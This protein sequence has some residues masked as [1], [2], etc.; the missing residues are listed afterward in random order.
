MGDSPKV[1]IV[2]LN[3]NGLDFLKDCIASIRKQTYKHIEIVVTDNNSSDGS[4]EF[5]RST[6]D[7]VLVSHDDNYG[8]AR[9]NND[10]AQ[11]A[12]GDFLFFLNND[13]VLYPD[14]IEKLVQNFE[15]RS[16]LSPVQVRPWKKGDEGYAHVGMD[17]FGYPYGKEDSRLN[18]PF[19]VDGA[20][21]FIK[22]SDFF[23][24]G[25]FDPELFIFQEDI[26][27]SWRAQMMGYH[28]LTCWEAKFEHFGGGAVLGGVVKKKKYETSYFR[29]FLNEKNVLRNILKNY[30]FPLNILIFSMIAF[31]HTGEILV[32]ALLGKWKVINCYLKAYW[33]NITH[34]SNTL[35]FRKAVQEKRSIGDWELLKRMYWSYSKLIAFKNLGIPHFK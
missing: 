10:G 6:K 26:D 13:T 21:I 15:P 30:S 27:L 2:I 8:Y 12:T 20:G 11:A 7:I 3:Y 23:E 4:L 19:Y 16:L 1:S 24:I 33:W 18:K 35:Q 31:L 14:C 34:L 28:I 29:R 17:I 25:Q 22:K 32:L 9:S 5:L